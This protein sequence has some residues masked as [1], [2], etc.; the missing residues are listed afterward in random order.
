MHNTIK[1][2][3]VVILVIA[4]VVVVEITMKR[5]NK[6]ANKIGVD[7]AEVME[8][9]IAQMVQML[10]ITTVENMDTMQRIALSRRRWKKIRI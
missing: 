7:E 3:V 2:E 8:E 5:K 10:S 6:E 1:E 4:M 9:V